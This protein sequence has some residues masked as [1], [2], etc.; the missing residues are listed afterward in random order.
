MNMKRGTVI[1]LLALVVAVMFAAGEAQ[2]TGV[3]FQ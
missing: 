1:F 2:A 3:Y